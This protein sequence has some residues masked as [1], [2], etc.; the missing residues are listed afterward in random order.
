M[1]STKSTLSLQN[2]Q[3]Q[4]MLIIEIHKIHMTKNRNQR[5]PTWI[6]H[7]YKNIY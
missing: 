5:N 1:K 7:I 3:K 4:Q 2:P 6:Y